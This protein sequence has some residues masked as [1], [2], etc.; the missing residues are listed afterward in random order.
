M[1]SGTLD[2]VAPAWWSCPDYDRTFGPEVREVCGWAGF[3][4]DPEQQ[5]LLDATFAFDRRN[6]V[7]ARDVAVCAPRQNLKTGFLKMCALGWLYVTEQPLT[8]WSAHEFSTAQEAF[9]DMVNL[10]EDAPDLAAE[11]LKIHRG[12]GEEAI[13][14]TG[15]RRLK[16]KARTK[17][18]GR[19]LTGNKIVLDEAMYLTAT[20]MGALVP[21]LRA[22][23][24]PQL[25]LAGSAGML[26][27]ATW[28]TYRDRGRVGDDPSLVWAEWG[29][30]DPSGCVSTAC[31]HRADR[32][33]CVLD[34]RV[35][36]RA[37]NTALGRRI[38]E[39]TL[40][41][42]RSKLDPVEFARETLGWWQDP[43]GGGGVID[44]GVWTG[45]CTGVQDM[46]GPVFA[47]E[48]ALDR[49]ATT[50]GA[51]WD[52]DGRP[53][54][55]IVE[56]GPGVGWVVDRMVELTDRYGGPGVVVDTG[57]EAAGLVEPLTEA[58][59]TVFPVNGT[60][61]TVA[62][63]DFYDLATS[64]GM[65]HSGDP[66]ITAAIGAARWKDVGDGSRAFTRRK[67]AGNIAALYAVVLALWGR[68]H[69]DEDY[70]LMD[71]I[72]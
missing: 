72:G 54:A 17:A 33:G 53:H 56:D 22:V 39:E 40:A 55:E 19:G 37:T 12:N 32:R 36:W 9:R 49:A 47:L 18:G 28:R 58:G 35:R 10:I 16:F 8:V 29:D 27:S 71:S 57:T 3:V 21:T 6:R 44:L 64:G 52:V 38:D 5:M 4:P 41:V 43:P 11:V 48:V 23:P 14:L 59:L 1:P 68:R 67:S 62:C 66:A 7:V 31:D 65:S 51:V 69:G 24:D 25:L 46:V 63:G 13:E 34:D 61:R 42:D 70:D 60:S 2:L 45:L 15:N 20:H 30:P 50:I 26:E